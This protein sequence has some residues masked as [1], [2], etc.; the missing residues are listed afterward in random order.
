MR[1]PG[2]AGCGWHCDLSRPGAGRHHVGRTGWP[3]QLA[4]L[5]GLP[6]CRRKRVRRGQ[7]GYYPKWFA[8]V[9]TVPRSMQHFYSASDKEG[10]VGDDSIRVT[11]NDG[12]TAKI[13][14][15]VK[16]QLPADDLT[17]C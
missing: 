17:V 3:Q 12:G 5:P 4:G 9:W 16:I 7:P 10:G 13:S 8:T 15:F 6:V 1:D 14:S 2:E 11:F